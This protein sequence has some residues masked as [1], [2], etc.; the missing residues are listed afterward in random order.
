MR[1]RAQLW[2][3]GGLTERPPKL[4]LHRARVGRRG[5]GVLRFVS[6]FREAAEV[7]EEGAPALLGGQDVDAQLALGMLLS[8]AAQQLV[9]A[10]VAVVAAGAPAGRRD[11]ADGAVMLACGACAG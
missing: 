7:G 8:A 4:A 10:V 1:G 6:G 11:D 5:A 3:G 9:G 2:G